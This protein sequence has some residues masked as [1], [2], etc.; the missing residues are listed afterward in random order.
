[1]GLGSTTTTADSVV[2]ADDAKGDEKIV[3][4]STTEIA[5]DQKQQKR[6]IK[7]KLDALMRNFDIKGYLFLVLTVAIHIPWIY[8][9]LTVRSNIE[10]AA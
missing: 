5:S 10:Y 9:L 1:V 7:H 2:V 4:E 3:R 8:A 6:I